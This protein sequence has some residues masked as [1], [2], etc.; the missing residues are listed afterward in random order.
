MGCLNYPLSMNTERQLLTW[1]P[2]LSYIVNVFG[3]ILKL[4]S[5][6][7]TNRKLMC[8]TCEV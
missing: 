4:R 5:M 2:P 7:Q 1:K 3:D 6:R 8:V